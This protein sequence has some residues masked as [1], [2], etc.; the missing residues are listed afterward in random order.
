[1]HDREASEK[2]RGSGRLML[3]E[4]KYLDDNPQ[5]ADAF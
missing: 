4:N 2:L 3:S 5:N 1:M